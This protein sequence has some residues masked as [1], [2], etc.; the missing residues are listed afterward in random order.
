MSTWSWGLAFV[1]SILALA[2]GSS[3]TPDDGSASTMCPSDLPAACPASP[4]TYAKNIAPLVQNVCATCHVAGGSQADRLIDTYDRIYAQRGAV[5]S[6][7]YACRM[8]PANGPPLS[9]EGRKAFMEWLVCGARN[10]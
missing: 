10:D 9:A 6:Q 2:C 5:L 4:P 1:G 8:P 3:S 7:V